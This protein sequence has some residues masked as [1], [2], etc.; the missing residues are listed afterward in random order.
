MCEPPKAFGDL[1]RYAKTKAIKDIEGHKPAEE[2]DDDCDYE[3]NSLS[4]QSDDSSI[5]EEPKRMPAAKKTTT[6]PAPKPTTSP[7]RVKMADPP[8]FDEDTTPLVSIEAM[9]T[10]HSQ[11]HLEARICEVEEGYICLFVNLPQGK[12]LHDFTVDRR[13]DDQCV[14]DIKSRSLLATDIKPWVICSLLLTTLKLANVVLLISHKE[15][16]L[17]LFLSGSVETVLHSRGSA[18]S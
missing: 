2:S 3:D 6:K 17:L 10:R 11:T 1:V 14:V 4:S 18:S 15:S 13:R 8:M 16:P 12:S 7:V 9:Q 5:N